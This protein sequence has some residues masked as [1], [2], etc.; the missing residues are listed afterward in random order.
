MARVDPEALESA[1][2]ADTLTPI[3]FADSPEAAE[4]LAPEPAEE[5]PEPIIS[6]LPF[7]I[8]GGETAVLEGNRAD[9]TFEDQGFGIVA[10]RNGDSIDFLNSVDTVEFKDGTFPIADLLTG[11]PGV[12]DGPVNDLGEIAETGAYE[13]AENNEPEVG[14]EAETVFETTDIAAVPDTAPRIPGPAGRLQL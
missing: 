1:V 12:V 2:P 9:Y 13:A 4:S 7:S 8:D 3:S 5:A 11:A 6:E 14:N 10:V